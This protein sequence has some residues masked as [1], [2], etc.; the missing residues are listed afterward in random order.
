MLLRSTS[1][2]RRWWRRCWR[3]TRARPRRR[4]R[5]SRC[6]RPSCTLPPAM[7]CTT[8]YRLRAY[9]RTFLLASTLRSGMGLAFA[10][11]S[12]VGAYLCI[13]LR[14]TRRRGRWWRRCW[15]RTRAR[16]RRGTRCSH[17]FCTL[18]PSALMPCVHTLVHLLASAMCRVGGC[19]CMLLRSSRHRRGWWRR[20]WWRIRALPQRRTLC[21]RRAR[22][23]SAL[24]STACVH[25][26]THLL[27]FARCAGWEAALASCCG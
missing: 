13:W 26:R 21:A 12:G 27:A 16:P 6:A 10:L 7:M 20:C 5:T 4:S 24:Q 1:R 2:R 9:T 22:T 14:G 17:H 11:C 3:L 18:I 25:T 15:R 19:H 23:P 8:V